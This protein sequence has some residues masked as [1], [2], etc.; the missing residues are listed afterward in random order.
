MPIR[1]QVWPETGF[2]FLG[3][4]PDPGQLPAA[5]KDEWVLQW[6]SFD[7]TGENMGQAKNQPLGAGWDALDSCPFPDFTCRERCPASCVA[8]RTGSWTAKRYPKEEH[9]VMV[10]PNETCSQKYLSRLA[11]S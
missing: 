7:P 8:S 6:E 2:R 3:F 1:G 11:P 4:A 5:G 9:V 10:V